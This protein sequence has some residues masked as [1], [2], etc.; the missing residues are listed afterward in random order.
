M[1]SRLARCLFIFSVLWPAAAAGTDRLPDG[2]VT[3]GQRDIA[4][5][6]LTGPSRI[7]DHGVLGDAIEATGL[8]VKMRDGRELSFQL[9]GASVFEDRRARLADLDGDGRDKIIVV[10]SYLDRGA[11]LAVFRPVMDRS[12]GNRLELIAETSPIGR[13]HRWLNP[14]GIADFDGDGQMEVA[15]VVTPHIGGTLKIYQLRD[16]RLVEEWSSEGYSNHAMGSRNLDLALVIPG[17][18][19]GEISGAGGPMLVLP[20]PW[21]TG[22]RRVFFRDGA[23]RVVDLPLS[24]QH[25]ITSLALGKAEAKLDAKSDA[26]GR[27]AINY[28]TEGG[29]AGV[30]WLEY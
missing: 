22:L 18:I 17:V 16:G 2:L 29:R 12:G 20:N 6:W 7:Y 10:R 15:L 23:Y 1:T 11:A 3:T 13:A 30:V 19:P 27:L 25:P 4:A 8:A 24:L 26:G 28:L 5:A 14:A 21:R 9:A